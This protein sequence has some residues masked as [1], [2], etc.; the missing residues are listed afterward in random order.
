MSVSDA[1]NTTV[2][3]PTELRDPGGWHTGSGA[4]VTVPV[5][6]W[7]EIVVNVRSLSAAAGTRRLLHGVLVN[8]VA[9]DPCGVDIVYDNATSLTPNQ[10][11]TKHAELQADDNVAVI[12][13]HTFGS[14][15]NFDVELSVRR[16]P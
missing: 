2:T 12:L 10:S 11:S 9:I 3:Y 15:I 8:S 16:I 13:F 14:S 5:D 6:D 1:T 4:N 7:Y